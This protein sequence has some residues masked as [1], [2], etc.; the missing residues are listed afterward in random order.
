MNEIRISRNVLRWIVLGAGIIGFIVMG[1]AILAAPENKF[2][3]TSYI[4]LG[5]GIL[6]LAGFVLVDPEGLATSMT[7]RSGQYGAANFLISAA[8][9]VVLGIVY[10]GVKQLSTEGKIT[11]YDATGEHK[12]DLSQATI[13]VLSSLKEDVK[14]TVFYT[15]RQDQQKKEAELWLSKYKSYSNGK[16]SYEFVDPD[17]HPE[18]AR[19]LNGREGTLVFQQA[20]RKAEA[21][22][23]SENELTNAVV[24]VILGKPRILYFTTGHGERDTQGFD[25]QGLSQLAGSLGKANFTVNTLNL[26]EKGSVP[27][28]ANAVVIAGPTTPF[29]PSEIEALKTYVD[30]G[31]SLFVMTGDPFTGSG[32][33]G[34]GVLSVAY[35]PDGTKIAT[36]AADGLVKLWDAASGT[37][38]LSLRGHTSAVQDVAFSPDGTTLASA[39][40]DNQVLFWDTTSGEQT[41]KIEDATKVYHLAY[42]PDG[43]LLAAAGSDGLVHVWDAA[44]HA[45]ASYSPITTDP[46]LPLYDIAFSPDGTLLAAVGGGATASG[47]SSG[48]VY[49]WDSASGEQKV[50]N[51]LHA[52]V[53]LDVDFS[54]DGK[55]LTTAG[56]DGTEG[57]LDIASGQG[58]TATLYP[59][60]GIVSIA[61][62][63]DG[64]KVY[65]LADGTIHI[66]PAPGASAPTAIPAT[67]SASPD[68]VLS[69]HTGLIWALSL[70]P[71]GTQF[72]S[73]GS[74]G[75]ARIWSVDGTASLHTMIA[76]TV[77]DTLFNYLATDWG[78]QVN[79]SA[80]VD[81]A[82][83]G[84]ISQSMYVPVVRAYGDTPIT[85]QLVDAQKPTF[86]ILARVINKLQPPA[87]VT[88]NGLLSTTSDNTGQGRMISWGE[89][90]NPF[91]SGANPQFDAQDF[92]GPVMIGVSAENSTTKGR[93]VVIGDADFVSNDWVSHASYGNLDLFLN[94]A[95]WLARSEQALN[96]PGPNVGTRTI[97]KP[98]SSLE[99]WAYGIGSICLL[100]LGIAIFGFVMWLVRRA[101]R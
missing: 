92:P 53:V 89:T 73:A 64:R 13:D 12:Y 20:D 69:E 74:D 18:I 23:L 3:T 50:H 75:T 70:S 58:S 19:P 25:G 55:T 86:F 79:E 88:I 72:V 51:T 98:L 56:Y 93:V 2:D 96:L 52:A 82:T 1:I 39:G 100:P 15:N 87:E 57:T 63:A 46:A 17:A 71:D 21:T 38:L 66:R 101:R 5:V 7:G 33:A 62:L 8:L 36:A 94:A 91:V 30:K 54:A 67:E 11:P 4:A 37:E 16:L 35:S 78:I 44:T 90:T 26:L 14:I 27:A 6:G 32:A 34:N 41:G 24:E 68:T 65:A 81:L 99:S 84:E 95:D 22:S 80:A 76:A 9:I 47:G 60:S 29:A 45:P 61:T 43:K 40:A 85:R 83:A 77:Q 28:D 31:G 42:S 97:D 48:P 10:A 59:E 49:V